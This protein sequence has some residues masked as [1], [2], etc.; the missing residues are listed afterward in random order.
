MRASVR[1]ILAR[2]DALARAA[3]NLPTDT[4]PLAGPYA[5]ESLANLRRIVRAR[6]GEYKRRVGAVQ[7]R[8]GAERTILRPLYFARLPKYPEILGSSVKVQAGEGL[9]VLTSVVYM[10][11]ASESG[12]NLCPFATAGCAAACLGHNSGR[13]VYT[14]SANARLWKTA[15]YLADRALWRALVI[16]ETAALVRKA[17]RAGMIP[18]VRIDGST[19]TGEGARMAPALARAFPTLRLYDYTKDAARAIAAARGAYGARYHVTFSRSGENDAACRAVLDAGGNVAA[20]FDVRARRPKGALPA[21]YRG[22]AVVDGDVSDARFLD[23]A[24]GAY[25][26]L[27]F[28]A[29]RD[30]AGALAAAGA[31]VVRPRRKARA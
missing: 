2:A 10:A 1:A 21:T 11:P 16:A 31:F 24:R 8:T 9:G 5:G 7:A 25:V 3:R 22:R 12:L 17:A 4:G 6:F 28:K 30:R 29:E 13:V 14:D 20:V 23:G 19:D 15:L 18:A 27:R 26:G